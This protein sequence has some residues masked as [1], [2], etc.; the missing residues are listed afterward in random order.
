MKVKAKVMN[1]QIQTEVK[2]VQ[3]DSFEYTTFNIPVFTAT[4]LMIFFV[5]NPIS[6]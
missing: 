4:I 5:I 2:K 6:H 3:A 1:Q